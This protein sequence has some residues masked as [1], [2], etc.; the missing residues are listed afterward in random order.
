MRVPPFLPSASKQQDSSRET[1][2]LKIPPSY[3]AACRSHWPS[4]VFISEM[5]IV[6]STIAHRAPTP[7]TSPSMVGIVEKTAVGR[8]RQVPAVAPSYVSSWGHG[9]ATP[10]SLAASL[11]AQV[12]SATLHSTESWEVVV[13]YSIELACGPRRWSIVRRFSEFARLH[14]DL[15]H[16]APSADIFAFTHVHGPLLG[17]IAARRYQPELIEARLTALDE[18]LARACTMLEFDSRLSRFLAM[19]F[20]AGI[21]AFRDWAQRG[22]GAVEPRPCVLCSA[23]VPCEFSE[24]VRPAAPSTART[25]NSMSLQ[26][27]RR[28][29][30]TLA[31]PSRDLVRRGPQHPLGTLSPP[32]HHLPCARP[33]RR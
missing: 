29:L 4:F 32:S 23:G 6:S 5:P 24:E 8:H 14:S 9:L 30:C 10:S 28:L 25:L 15:G 31:A 3:G 7:T 17:F 27:P 16:D 20:D 11:R 1:N 19:P 18:W 2:P 33:P 26:N 13:S 12:V 22:E 21:D